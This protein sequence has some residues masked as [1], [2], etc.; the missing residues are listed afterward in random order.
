MEDMS[1]HLHRMENGQFEAVL[2]EIESNKTDIMSFGV[3][4]ELLEK[5]E[6][7]KTRFD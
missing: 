7:S 1:S 3:T 6:E 2:A 4:R 5:I